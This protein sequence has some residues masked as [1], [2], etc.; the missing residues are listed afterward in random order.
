MEKCQSICSAPIFHH[1]DDSLIRII[2]EIQLSD[3]LRILP[4]STYPIL[5]LSK[6][7][8]YHGIGKSFFD[9]KDVYTR[10]QRVTDCKYSFKLSEITQ[11][12]LKEYQKNFAEA[13]KRYPNLLKILQEVKMD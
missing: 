1:C 3:L 6:D 12:D 11:D 5:S 4:D 7:I 10:F 13:I 9:F 2:S 8:K